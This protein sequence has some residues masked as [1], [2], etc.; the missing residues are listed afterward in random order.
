MKE[1]FDIIIYIIPSK[2]LFKFGFKIKDDNGKDIGSISGK[3]FEI[4]RR[5]N[6]SSRCG[7]AFIESTIGGW[8]TK[9]DVRVG[10]RTLKIVRKPSLFNTRVDITGLPWSIKGVCDNYDYKILNGI[11]LSGVWQIQ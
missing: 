11:E 5:L 6:V 4:D 10:G 1:G 2:N 3:A 9:L 8:N 7:S